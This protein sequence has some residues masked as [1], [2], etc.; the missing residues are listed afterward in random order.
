MV[1]SS[2]K[3]SK[4]AAKIEE[5][6]DRLE[7]IPNE[8]LQ[9]A[10][11]DLISVS[12]YGRSYRVQLAA[13]HTNLSS[14][15]KTSDDDHDEGGRVTL[16]SVPRYEPSNVR[17]YSAE[18]DFTVR[19]HCLVHLSSAED[20]QTQDLETTTDSICLF[21]YEVRLHHQ[22]WRKKVKMTQ[23]NQSMN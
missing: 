23:L 12:N 8:P 11:D 15:V 16:I 21:L 5:E 2:K 22:P 6:E 7:L 4:A 19:S 1:K 14:L 18:G 10:W 3:S 13:L 20:T 9:P 17:P